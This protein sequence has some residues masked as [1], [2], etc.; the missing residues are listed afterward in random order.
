MKTTMIAAVALLGASAA[1]AQTSPTTT[2]TP[3]SMPS[4]ESM[5]TPPASTPGTGTT[6]TG[7]SGT[8][9]T[10]PATGMAGDAMTEQ[11]ARQKLA[12]AG[13]GSVTGLKRGAD[14]QW[15]A[16][17]KK[18]NKQESVMIAPDGTV[19]PKTSK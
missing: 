3:G 13:Y 5:T 16:M 2:G 19:S 4:T 11:M 7:M 8:G 14:G 18:G 9:T 1:L 17:T 10:G 6:G 12:G 15:E